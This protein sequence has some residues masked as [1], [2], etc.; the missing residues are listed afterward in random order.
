M[1]P[2]CCLNSSAFSIYLDH[3]LPPTSTKNLIHLSQRVRTGNIAKYDNSQHYGEPVPP[4]YDMTAIPNEFPLVFTYGWKDA[5][6]DVMDVQLLLNDLKDHH[7]NNLDVL[8][9]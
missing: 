6:Y 4:V 1:S 2:N 9:R 3:G 7:P 8:S 5:L